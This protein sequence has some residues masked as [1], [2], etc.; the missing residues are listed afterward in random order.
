[1]LDN[2]DKH[3]ECSE[4]QLFHNVDALVGKTAELQ[5]FIGF[6]DEQCSL[7]SRANPRADLRALK[8]VKNFLLRLELWRFHKRDIFEIGATRISSTEETQRQR[9][10][11]KAMQR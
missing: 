8:Q 1:M 4:E 11:D 10:I 3:S 2:K 7:A 9:I 6:I 5:W